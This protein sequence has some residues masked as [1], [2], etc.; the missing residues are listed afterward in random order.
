[1]FKK[2]CSSLDTCKDTA[3]EQITC[4]S[5]L[6]TL[7]KDV[8]KKVLAEMA[9]LISEFASAHERAGEHLSAQQIECNVRRQTIDLAK[10]LNMYFFGY[11][12]RHTR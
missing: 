6:Y 11:C 9:M 12:R 7:I 2:A 3:V 10:K 1:M 8:E 4:L 5:E